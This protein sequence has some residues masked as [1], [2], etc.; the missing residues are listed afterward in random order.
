MKSKGHLYFSAFLIVISGYAIL[1]ASRWSFKTGF[2]PLAVAIPLLILVLI[3][4]YLE[5]FTPAEASKGPAIDAEFSDD[6]APEIARR[7]V[8][9]IFSWIAAFILFVA[10]IGFP[11][12]VPLFI[13]C[14]LKFQSDV[15]WLS[16]IALTVIAWGF[17]YTLFQ[18]L[19]H[20]QFEAGLIQSWLGL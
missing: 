9:T 2:F 3:H 20:I 14:Y 5:L 10:L 7:R 12:T 13:F 1:A 15:T 18:R 11:L 8:I 6:V 19:V 4:L 16:T 17:F